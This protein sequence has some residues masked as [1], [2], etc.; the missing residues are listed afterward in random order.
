[1]GSER[2]VSPESTVIMH[3]CIALLRTLPGVTEE[4]VQAVST[5]LGIFIEQ[6]EGSE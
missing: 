4:T 5:C 6:A 1:M 2:T 3:H